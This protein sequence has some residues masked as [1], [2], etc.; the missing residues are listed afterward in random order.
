MYKTLGISAGLSSGR[1]IRRDASGRKLVPLLAQFTR[2]DLAVFMVFTAI[3]VV[4]TVFMLN[5]SL[6]MYAAPVFQ[7]VGITASRAES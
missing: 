3:Q 4:N 7:C 1:L 2:D 5:N 6:R